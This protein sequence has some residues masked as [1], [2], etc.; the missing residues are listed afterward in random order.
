MGPKGKEKD[1]LFV[2]QSST[3]NSILLV[4]NMKIG[5]LDATT[6]NFHHNSETQSEKLAENSKTGKETHKNWAYSS[7]TVE[8]IV[9]DGR[10]DEGRVKG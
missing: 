8:A 3:K 10:D 4:P 7:F 9:E 2:A 5:I 6:L 1:F